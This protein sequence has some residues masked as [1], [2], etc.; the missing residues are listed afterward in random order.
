MLAGQVQA[1]G[2]ELQEA[3]GQGG[4]TWRASNTPS[5]SS[6]RGTEPYLICTQ[7]EHPGVQ[8]KL[9]GN[10]RFSRAVQTVP[11]TRCPNN[12]PGCIIIR[13]DIITGRQE[14]VRYPVLSRSVMSD[15]LRPPQTV[16]PPSSSVQGILQAR[17][18]QW[19]AI[20]HSG[21]SSP[22]WDRT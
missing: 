6:Q 21:R 4:R 10:V 14:T 16:A 13:A 11:N 17:I 8:Q 12:E 22:P 3:T 2:R 1:Q 7:P 18:L 19:V 5:G 20:P 9:L 15:S